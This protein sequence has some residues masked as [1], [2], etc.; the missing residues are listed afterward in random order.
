MRRKARR[1]GARQ[2]VLEIESLGARG[3][4][5]G[6]L[7]G[8]PVFVAGLLPGEE[9]RIRL[10]G[11]REGAFRGEAIELLR[12]SPARV[13]PP[14]PHFGSCG[15][16]KLQHLEAAAYRAWKRGIAVEALARRGLASAPV[17]ALVEVPSESRR[18]ATLAA[19]R[20]RDG[21]LRLGFHETRGHAVVD[22]TACLILHPRLFALLAPL[23][24]LLGEVLAGGERADLAL[25]LTETGVDLLLTKPDAPD[26]RA[27]EA[28]AAFA[29]NQDLAR[30]GWRPDEGEESEPVALRRAPLVRFSGVAVTPPPGGFLQPTA[31]G[32]A[33]LV[34][35]V[36]RG[37]PEGGSRF[38]DLYAGCGTFTFALAGR[39]QVLAVE[40]ESAALE[41]LDA[42]A[43]RAGLGQAIE[44]ELRDL[45]RRPLM[46]D[47]LA[48][49]DALVFDPPRAGARAQAE[50]IAASRLPSVVAVSCN[51]HSFARDARILVDGG[52][53]LLE[54]I[55]IDQFPWTGHLELV[56]QFR[57]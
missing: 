1:G 15:G 24:G 13:A 7:E 33:A 5:V 4:G 3:D 26:L 40:G 19:S 36:L 11:A 49:F 45:S 34:E 52:F 47:E 22:L 50:E 51:P 27:R 44:T 17:G 39:G 28:L 14:C 9:A 10:T 30:L 32:E 54:V 56:A 48:G 16:C 55:P 20:G 29:E 42:A 12:E 23:R 41:A 6:R 31:A 53:R 46:A 18:R 8:R 25:T 38:A 2:A 21:R 37:L 43:R 35:A 57:R